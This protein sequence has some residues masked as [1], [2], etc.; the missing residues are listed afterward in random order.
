MYEKKL[1]KICRLVYTIGNKVIAMSKTI[2]N[3]LRR[4]PVLGQPSVARHHIT[5][6][7]TSL[8]LLKVI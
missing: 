2:K 4:I 6:R 1:D 5:G 3:A 7:D 8:F